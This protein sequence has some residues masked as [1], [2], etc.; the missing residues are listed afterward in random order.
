MVRDL[1][2]T[3]RSALEP[4]D[5]LQNEY[6]RPTPRGQTDWFMRLSMYLMLAS[7]RSEMRSFYLCGLYTAS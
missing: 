3:Y 7:A 4:S 2:T 1:A 5:L 6:L